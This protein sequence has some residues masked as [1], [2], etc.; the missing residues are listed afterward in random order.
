MHVTSVWVCE[1]NSNC[2]NHCNASWA[3]S[4]PSSP[5]P[6]LHLTLPISACLAPVESASH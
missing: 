4:W 6:S 1:T 2:N 5:K 3:V